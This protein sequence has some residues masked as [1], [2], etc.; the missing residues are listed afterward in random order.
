MRETSARIYYISC[1]LVLA[2][3]LSAQFKKRVFFDESSQKKGVIDAAGNIIVPALYDDMEP[4]PG[5]IFAGKKDDRIILFNGDGSI[6][7]P[8][9]YQH[10][11]AHF[12][13]FH[14]QYG[15][16]AV[17]K[18]DKIPNSWGMIRSDGKVIIP[19][20]YQYLRAI[21]PKL[22][23]AR[24][25]EKELLYFFNEKG[26]LLGNIPG[27]RVDPH[28]VDNTCFSVE[29]A[30][31][32]N[33]FYTSELQPIAKD[34]PKSGYWTNGEFTILR[35]KGDDL[36]HLGMVNKAGKTIIPFDYQTFKHGLQNQW[37]AIKNNSD[38]RQETATVF[39]AEGK[40]IIPEDHYSIRPFGE[41][42]LAYGKLDDSLTIFGSDGKKILPGKYRYSRIYNAEN[43]VREIHGNN[44]DDY[45]ELKNTVSGEYYV[46]HKSGK[47]LN[48][49]GVDQCKY[50][51]DRHPFIIT[52]TDGETGF[53]QN[54]LVD[55][56]G[57]KLLKT[58]FQSIEFTA[59]PHIF[60]VEKERGQGVQV[61]NLKKNKLAPEMY[62]NTFWMLN[63]HYILMKE[64]GCVIL[65]N[66]MKELFV[67][68][69]PVREPADLHYVAYNKAKVLSGNLIAIYD[70][71]INFPVFTA[72]NERGDTARIDPRLYETVKK[73]KEEVVEAS[74]MSDVP[75]EIIVTKEMNVLEE[76][77]P[78]VEVIEPKISEDEIM[79]IV[80]QMPVF[81]GGES[82]FLQYI[83]AHLKYPAVAVENGIQGRV[84]IG[85]V[86]EKDGSLTECN[87]VRDIG[88]GCGQAA[89]ELI[90][91]L[92]KMNPGK[93]RG[94]VV[95]TKY[96]FLVSFRL[97]DR[98]K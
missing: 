60:F 11:Q 22:L 92:P 4:S 84:V 19:E 43:Y 58:T 68:D 72:I 61:Y 65:S 26:E 6:R 8:L 62:K 35:T 90:K 33:S 55:M 12:N 41:I 69:R 66:K 98:N 29:G 79:I 52:K 46:L 80:E 71:Y 91:T 25:Y 56:K 96:T 76:V 23:V 86:V 95:R 94:K 88:G 97:T 34:D 73:N 49:E 24:T 75:R 31:Q 82:A 14:D 89:L 10:I 93:N 15:F 30:D 44:T 2:T 64:R 5:V 85:C 27:K 38:Y 83:N 37:I 77:S 7:I 3:G 50:L 74:E 54:Q 57:N 47:F 59:F 67:T 70:E 21:N 20:K 87:V 78:P 13:N 18:N 1:L 36:F 32:N 9:L 17:T 42:Y 39:N 45:L 81:P 51:S 28:E 40:I 63:N 16:A 48:L 53:S